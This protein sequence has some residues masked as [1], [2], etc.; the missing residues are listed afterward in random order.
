MSPGLAY[1]RQILLTL[2]SILPVLLFLNFLK[3]KNRGSEERKLSFLELKV[4][5]TK[6]LGRG[7][8]GIDTRVL[9]PIFC[10][11]G[12]EVIMT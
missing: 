11:I 12:V 2:N 10:Q 5:E 7:H 9:E 8:L 6:Q 1:A 4:S 3:V